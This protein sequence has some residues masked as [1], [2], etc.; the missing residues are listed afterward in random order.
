MSISKTLNSSKSTVVTDIT[1]LCDVVKEFEDSGEYE[2][3]SRAM[4]K[5]WLGV[6]IRPDVNGL[7]VG[8][9]A[10]I[11]GRIGALSGWLGS[12][13]LVPGSQELA[14]DII[15][16]A[17]TLFESIGDDQNWAEARSDLAICY[18]R[19]GAFDEAR[20]ILQDVRE[21]G[22]EFSPQLQ[23]K[24]LLRSVNVEIST[25]RYSEATAFIN[26]ATPIIED[27]GSDLLRG[28]LYF[29]RALIMRRKAEDEDRPDLLS[30][31]IQDYRRAAEFYQRAGH[32]QFLASV[33]TNLG[34]LLLSL[35]SYAE[36]HLHFDA[37]LE[38]VTHQ[39]DMGIAAPVYDN[40]AQAF[41]A[42]GKLEEAENA[43][44]TSVIMLRD[45]GEQASLA[46]SLT[47]LAKILSRRQ[48]F[49]PAMR[50]FTEA[51]DAALLVGDKESAGNALL[52]QIEE[53]YLV[54]SPE[55][56]NDLY[57][58]AGDLLRNSAKLTTLK[59]LR[60]TAKTAGTVGLANTA[61]LNFSWENFHLPDAVRN[62]EGEIILRALNESGGRVTKAA[63]MLGLSHQNLSLILHQR[64][65]DLKEHCVKR[66]PRSTS[67]VKTH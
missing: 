6:G 51:K 55:E 28:K 61:S 45:G 50:S 10:V 20:V 64:H 12:M 9:K 58:E 66:K 67:K 23:G 53:L 32:L 43:A 65:R 56:F 17:A 14:K 5:W 54:L 2:R 48:H 40:K 39:N 37:A 1:A 33:E 57:T 52:T 11:L 18:W 63:K 27:R 22:L 30:S 16:E 3:A 60:E 59:R 42:E 25:R 49:A 34:F 29:H 21:S 41:L 46:Q 19:E 31:A 44:R 24:L 62:Y 15:S 8:N 35:N 7:S 47:T 38:I 36:A 4:G 26:E 13:Q